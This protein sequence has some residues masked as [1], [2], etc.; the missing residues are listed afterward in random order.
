MVEQAKSLNV[1][2][3]VIEQVCARPSKATQD[4]TGD[5][6]MS[7]L[8][9]WPMQVELEFTGEVG[10]EYITPVPACAGSRSAAKAYRLALFDGLGERVSTSDL[11]TLCIYEQGRKGFVA[12]PAAHVRDV[13][14]WRWNLQLKNPDPKPPKHSDPV[15]DPL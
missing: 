1:T 11:R 6:K 9:I 10:H 13:D 4:W 12:A 5:I 2:L 15:N 14:E 8:E 7:D 3:V